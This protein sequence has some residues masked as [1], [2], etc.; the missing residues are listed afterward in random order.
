MRRS[1]LT[2]VSLVAPPI[3]EVDVATAE[4][5]HPGVAI[6]LADTADPRDTV[7]DADAWAESDGFAEFDHA[8]VRDARSDG[9]VL[10]GIGSGLGR[11]T[12]EV[13]TRYQRFEQRRNHASTG[14]CFDAALGAHA[15]LHDMTRPLVAADYDH[16]LDTWQW[17]LRLEPNATRPAQLAALFHDIERIE[18]D[19]DRHV[20]HFSAEYVT[21]KEIHARRGADLA[22]RVL[23]ATG[24]DDETCVRVAEII[25]SRERT[26]DPEAT[27]IDDADALSFFSLSSDGYADYFGPDQARRK[28]KSKL[29]RLSQRARACLDAVR[30]RS[31]VAG[32]M[33][34]AA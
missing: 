13:L 34:T 6:G 24:L 2:R 21:F 23:G 11:T 7:L 12:R 10:L 22:A 3:V 19:Y 33:K 25:S 4:K 26:R 27:L 31:D 15:A 32:W 14:M 18:S 28:V 9:L 16:A 5:E 30:V 20:E 8:V 29:M 17:L 1:K